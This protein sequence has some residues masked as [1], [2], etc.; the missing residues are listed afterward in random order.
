[1]EDGHVLRA[2]NTI[3]S[4]SMII[5]QAVCQFEQNIR[6][7]PSFHPPLAVHRERDGA[8]LPLRPLDRRRERRY[9]SPSK[10]KREGRENINIA[11]N[12]SALKFGI[13]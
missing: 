6:R 1:M 5:S 10:P 8:R 2:R 7:R 3:F 13:R 4:C 9:E 11:D 12:I